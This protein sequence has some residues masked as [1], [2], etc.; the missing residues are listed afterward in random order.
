MDVLVFI[1]VFSH[2]WFPFLT[3]Y[4]S[5]FQYYSLY[6]SHIV[7]SIYFGPLQSHNKLYYLSSL[8]DFIPGTI[9]IHVT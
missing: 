8:S 6:I 2:I 4:S 1:L 5:N 9:F 3:L 7:Y